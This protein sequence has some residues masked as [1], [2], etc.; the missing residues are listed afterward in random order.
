M[1]GG[2]A[3]NSYRQADHGHAGHRRTETTNKKPHARYTTGSVV[4]PLIM[5][6]NDTEKRGIRRGRG[7]MA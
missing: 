7:M 5:A 3:F 2:V 4:H 6:G 1:K